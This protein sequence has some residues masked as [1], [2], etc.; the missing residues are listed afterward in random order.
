MMNNENTSFSHEI[1]C[2]SFFYGR[3]IYYV[4]PQLQIARSQLITSWFK[5]RDSVVDDPYSK[6]GVKVYCKPSR[7]SVPIIAVRRAFAA[8]AGSPTLSFGQATSPQLH[9]APTSFILI[10]YEH[11]AGTTS[12]WIRLMPKTCPSG[13]SGSSRTIGFTSSP[14]L[15]WTST[16]V[17]NLCREA[18]FGTPY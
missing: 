15:L 3:V 10:E 5:L 6:D 2:P 17:R 12:I 13:F 4:T 18:T 11:L 16:R 14:R 9:K 7:E 8:L 1:A